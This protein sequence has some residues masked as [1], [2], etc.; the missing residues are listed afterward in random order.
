MREM[1]SFDTDADEVVPSLDVAVSGHSQ[2]DR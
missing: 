1:A 2:T